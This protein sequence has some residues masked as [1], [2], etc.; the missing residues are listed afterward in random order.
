MSANGQTDNT[1]GLQQLEKVF[2]PHTKTK[3][4]GRRHLLIV[5]GHSSHVNMKFIKAADRLGIIILIL[6]P[7][8]THQLQPLDVGLFGPLATAYTNQ[9]NNLMFSSTGMISMS[10]HMFYRMFKVA[11]AA[12]FTSKNIISAFAKTGI[13]PY[14]PEIVTSAIKDLLCSTLGTEGI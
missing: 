1:L 14:A 11:Q 7:Y 12:A 13:W 10:K 2:D 9:L 3:A 5:D 4:R 8:S 6:L